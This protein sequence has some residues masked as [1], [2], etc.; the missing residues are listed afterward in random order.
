MRLNFLCANLLLMGLTALSLS[1]GW[2]TASAAGPDVTVFTL[3]G[4]QNYGS[5]GGIR[6]YAVGTTSC[7]IGDAPL[8]WC[9]Q[10]TGCAAGATTHDHPVIAQNM[11]R[12]KNGRFDQIGASWL[13][14]GFVSTNSTAA[15][16]GNG[17]CISPPAGGNQLGVGCTDP[18]GAGL[19]GGRP[20]GPKSE[21]NATTGAYPFPH[22]GSSGTQTAVW[23]QRVA[24]AESDMEASLNPGA[25][26]FVEGHYIAPDDAANGNGLNNASYAEVTVGVG[27][28]NLTTGA[29]VRQK[30]AIEVWPLIDPTVEF[31]NVDTATAPVQRFH[32][33]RKVT[34]L[35]GGQWH[36]E[37]AVH[38]MNSDRASDRFTVDFFGATTFSN[39][40][41]HDVDAH[42]GEPYDTTDWTG[43]AAAS[44]I[45]WEAP[46]FAST[47]NANAIR[48]GT[49][50]NF[51][52]DASR[53]P[54][55]IL[56]HTLKLFKAGEP[57]SLEFLTNGEPATFQNGYED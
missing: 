53:P 52:F 40:G 23:N 26:F 7:N 39:I 51:W 25:R 5:A 21:V 34:D 28:F 41:F 36:Y 11:Y 57:V 10:S 14:H 31:L 35:G 2:Q 48:W 29:T 38:N 50:Y 24:V 18:Y 20:L 13:K 3:S 15:Q 45:Q 22:S 49:L 56:R 46:P 47:A 8:N 44:A 27:T 9:D 6:G 37:Y 17:T 33:A 43:V 12:L 16:C 55:E 32:V 19:N 1:G 54:T 4:T 30:S 42:S